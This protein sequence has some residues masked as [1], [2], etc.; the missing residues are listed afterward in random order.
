M[1]EFLIMA[2]KVPTLETKDVDIG[3]LLNNRKKKTIY[4][5]IDLQAGKG[6]LIGL[7]GQNGI[8]KS[9]LLRTVANLQPSVS[10]EIL[11]NGKDL[12]K[13]RRSESA[14]IISFVSTEPV[15][16][17]NLKVFELV[18]LGRFPHTNWA[19]RLKQHDINLVKTALEMTGLLRLEQ[20]YISEISDGE[21]QRAMIARS[22]AQETEVMVLDEPTAFLDLQGK[23]EIVKILN[24]LATGAGKTV[25]FSTHDLNIAIH[26]ADK[27]WLMLPDKIV[28]GSPEDLIIN[29]RFR[30]VFKNSELHFDVKKGDFLLNKKFICEIGFT[31]KGIMGQWTKKALEKIGL[32]VSKPSN[33]DFIVSV[34]NLKRKIQLNLREDNKSF[35][36]TSIYSLSEKLKSI[37]FK[38]HRNNTGL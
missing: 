2:Y 35:E 15:K 8:G 36:Y 38:N 26:R 21:R 22:L 20:C 28:S 30:E 7:V 18:A 33:Q 12:N 23:Y 31:G 4:S 1:K 10:G 19:G 6:E 14:R 5:C 34:D 27:I 3:F 9:T 29:D 25:I 16:I 32:K 11:I 37:F 24:E 17:E 13:L